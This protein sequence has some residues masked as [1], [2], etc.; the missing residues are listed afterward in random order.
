MV[1]AVRKRQWPSLLLLVGGVAGAALWGLMITSEVVEL[2]CGAGGSP[3]GPRLAAFATGWP[4]LIGHSFADRG[5]Y[6]LLSFIGHYGWGDG[7]NGRMSYPLPLWMYVSALALLGIALRN[8]VRT[9]ASLDRLTRLSLTVGAAGVVLITFLAMYVTCRGPLQTIAGVQGRYFVPALFAI[10]PSD[11][12]P[13]AGGEMGSRP[14][15]SRRCSVS[16]SRPA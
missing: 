11:P 1:E 12:R 5:T 3:I 6:Y 13:R 16:G 7:P 8:D 2:R 14:R 4:W 9:R 10:A 15:G